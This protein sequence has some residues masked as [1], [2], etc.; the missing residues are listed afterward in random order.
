[1]S[2][3]ARIEVLFRAWAAFVYRWRWAVLPLSLIC[4]AWIGTALPLITIDNSTESYLPK[5][6]PQS[7]LYTEFRHQ[8]GLDSEL[9][10][11]LEPPEIFSIAFLERLR[12]LHE[13]LEAN[14]PYAAEVTSLLN[15]RNTRGEGDTLV[16][17]DL[18]EDWPTTEADLTALRERVLANP[19]YEDYVVSRN[20][21][22]AM[23]I[24]RPETYTLR[25]SPEDLDDAFEEEAEVLPLAERT[26]LDR[27][28]KDEMVLAMYAVLAGYQD[29]N[30]EIH[31]TGGPVVGYE[32][33]NMLR[34]DVRAYL[35][36]CSL[37]IFTL[38]LILFRRFSGLFLTAVTMLGSLVS[39]FG[40]MALLGIPFSGSLQMAPVFIMCV[41][42]CDVVHVLVLVYQRWA[43][44]ADKEEALVYAYG[45]SGMAIVMTS[46]TTAA[47]MLSFTT[48]DLAPIS[49]LGIVSA[50]GVGMAFL[51]TFTLLPALIAILP[52]RR[53]TRHTAGAVE[54]G[55]T[56]A[57]VGIGDL[58]TRRPKAVVSVWFVLFLV[59]AVGLGNIRFSHKPIEWFPE[60]LPVRIASNVLDES[61]GGTRTVEIMLDTGEENGLHDPERLRRMQEAKVFAEGLE[62]EGI[63]VGQ[64]SS[65]VDVIKETHQ[66]LNA[67]DSAFYQIPEERALIAQELLLFENSGTDDLE[68][69][70]DSQFQLARMTLRVPRADAVYYAEFL[71]MLEEGL[72]EIFGEELSFRISGSTPLLARIFLGMI[73][74]MAKSYAI[75]LIVITP[76]MILLIG[77]LRIGL[78]SMIPNIIPV[79]MTLGM[80]G[81]MG[82]PLDTSNIVIGSILIGLAVDD[83]I[84]FLHRFHRYYQEEPDLQ[85][86]VRRTMRTT[87]AALLFTSL[88]LGAGFISIGSMGTMLNTKSFGFVT[89]YG[90]AVAFFADIF[91]SP[92]LMALVVKKEKSAPATQA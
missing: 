44:G 18:L 81:W 48:A 25:G 24:V 72:S 75:A 67:N 55:L 6:D 61:L 39:S 64:A 42:V 52:L 30:F 71:P 21:R 34:E 79:L 62:H 56:R 22:L 47:G 23:I 50:M 16:V 88:V 41:C 46:I 85:L 90:I 65:L 14:I 27:Y 77:N 63:F 8:Y 4:T 73:S 9:V 2:I 15:A 70:T 78:V 60:D 36:V 5:D 11:A 82:I 57:L 20:G 26:F 58:A 33:T 40:V 10:I 43:E 19:L 45:H 12:A 37:V 83:T 91:L 54:N 13:D 68:R 32:I 59:S 66:A 1:M 31:T 35:A 74:S 89:A 49:Q 17:E 87:G 84:H 28:E 76:L 86:A 29:E 53:R 92:A 7:K 51:Y 3:K 69:L 80:M 38:L